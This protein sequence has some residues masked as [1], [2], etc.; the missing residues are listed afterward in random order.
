[1]TAL[2]G[3][4]LDDVLRSVTEQILSLGGDINPTKGAAKE[5]V[6]V[7]LELSNPRARLSRTETKGKPFS[8]LGEL[9]LVFSKEQ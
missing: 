9:F 8:C 4:T 3:E 7:L 5:I 6:G 2:V 1:M